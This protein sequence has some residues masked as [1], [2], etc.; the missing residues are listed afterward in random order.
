MAFT[1]EKKPKGLLYD[2]VDFINHSLNE[3]REERAAKSVWWFKVR[4]KVAFTLPN[5]EPS[6]VEFVF[7]PGTPK[8][9]V[10]PKPSD[11]ADLYICYLP[12]HI[13]KTG[14]NSFVATK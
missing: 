10:R 7:Q 11:Y 4:D 1:E 6:V 5:I 9:E 14:E 8:V 3:W 13:T 12:F 2:L